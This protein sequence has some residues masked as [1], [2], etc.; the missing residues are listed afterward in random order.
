MFFVK[1]E[2]PTG[3]V[4]SPIDVKVPTELFVQKIGLITHAVMV[5]MVVLWS[6]YFKLLYVEAEQSTIF[7]HFT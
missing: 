3:A 1:V 4:A 6:E 7:A 5:K 2:N